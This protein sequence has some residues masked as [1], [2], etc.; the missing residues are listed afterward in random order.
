MAEQYDV[1][2]PVPL[3]YYI[4]SV[5]WQ[6]SRGEF[7]HSEDLDAVLDILKSDFPEYLPARKNT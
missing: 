2:A 3:N 1:I 6:Y 4:K 7:L 5:Y